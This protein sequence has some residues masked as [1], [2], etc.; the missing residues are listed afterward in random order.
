[1]VTPS[2]PNIACQRTFYRRLWSTIRLLDRLFPFYNLLYKLPTLDPPS[3]GKP[4]RFSFLLEDLHNLGTGTTF[5]FTFTNRRQIDPTF[6][7]NQKYKAIT[8]TQ[9]SQRY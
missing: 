2:N 4:T 7:M 1:M 8:K 5:Y 3:Q 6:F 9:V